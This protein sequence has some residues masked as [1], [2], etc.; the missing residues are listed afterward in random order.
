M[1]A[2]P[3]LDASIIDDGSQKEMGLLMLE[4][5]A[6]TPGTTYDTQL[7]MFRDFHGGDL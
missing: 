2:L 4:T 5:A 7:Q 3:L 6:A 1:L